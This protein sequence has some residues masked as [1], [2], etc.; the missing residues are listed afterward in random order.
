MKKILSFI[1]ILLPAI[2]FLQPSKD[3]D[4]PYFKNIGYPDIK[5][6]LTD[7][8]TIFTKADLPID[9]T[10]VLIFFSPDCEHCQ[11]TVKEMIPKMDSLSNLFMVWNGP[12]YMPLEQDREFYTYY[13]LADYSNIILG[14]EMSYFMPLHYRI[15]ITPYAAVYKNGKFFTEFRKGIELNDLIAIANNTYV[16]PPQPLVETT[17]VKTE[18]KKTKKKAKKGSK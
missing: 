2:A 8:S 18:V 13:H 9:K 15:E 3:K 16:V 10:V 1:F 14:K 5:L 7:S 17:P 12:S 11:H 6:L 4:A